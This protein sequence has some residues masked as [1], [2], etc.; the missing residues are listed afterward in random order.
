EFCRLPQD[1]GELLVA[2]DPLSIRHCR[3]PLGTTPEGRTRAN[4]SAFCYGALSRAFQPERRL[5]RL[6]QG[7]AL[8]IFS[9]IALSRASSGGRG[10]LLPSTTTTTSPTFAASVAPSRYAWSPTPAIGLPWA[11]L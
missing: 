5:A 7:I 6:P 9:A 4:A 8:M 10:T 3:S 1:E 2:V 11:L